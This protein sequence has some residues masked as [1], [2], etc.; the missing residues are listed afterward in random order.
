RARV[1]PIKC[2]VTSPASVAEAF[3]TYLSADPSRRLDVLINNAGISDKMHPTGDCDMAM[4]EKNILVNMTGPF[5]TSQ[6]AIQQF[7]KQDAREGGQRGV[8]LNVISAAGLNGARA[9]VAYTASKHGT[10]GLTRST[11][12]FYGPKGIRC[13]AIMPGPMQTNMARSENHIADFHKEGLAVV[14]STFNT[15][16]G[17][18]AKQGWNFGWSPLEQVAKT[19]LVLCSDGMNTINGAL[20]PTDMGWTTV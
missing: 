13:L 1:H 6:A 8:I 16:H 18:P 3:S 7:L 5:V 9:G 14:V 11:A 15:V 12:A 20:V 2:D 10:V 17:D 4:W 19:V